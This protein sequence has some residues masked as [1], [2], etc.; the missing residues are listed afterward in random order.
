LSQISA[1][2]ETTLSS[3]QL[4]AFARAA[5]LNPNTDLPALLS[6]LERR[7]LVDQSASGVSVLGVTGRAILGHAADIFVELEPTKHEAAAIVFAEESSSAPVSH[8]T[9]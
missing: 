8:A 7:R 4:K 3:S 6:I 2:D 9:A 1:S 5:R